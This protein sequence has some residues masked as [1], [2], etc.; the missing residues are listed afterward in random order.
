[1]IEIKPVTNLDAS[2]DIPASKSYANRALIVSSLA[3]GRTVLKN[4]I[5]CDDTS[6]MIDG[7]RCLGVNISQ[8]SDRL[9]V[10]GT[11]GNFKVK[12]Q[13]LFLGNAGTAVRFLTSFAVLSGDRV[14]I[15]GDDRMNQRPLQ[16]LLDGLNQLGGI[17]YSI[18]NNGCTPIIIEKGS[19]EGGTVS[20]N[21]SKSSQYLSSILM[22]GP[23]AKKDVCIKVKGNPV[24][25]PYIDVTIKV[26]N[27]FGVCVDN[28]DYKDFFIRSG[29]KYSGR[30]YT[31]E[32]DAS[33]AS[34]FFA[35]AAVT[36][37]RIRVSNIDYNTLQGDIH[38]LDLLEKM[39]C[40]IRVEKGYIE[41][42]G[43]RLHGIDVDMSNM[44]DVVQTLSIVS[45][46]AEGETKITN[47]HNLRIKETDRLSALSAELK[48]VGA[49][50]VEFKDGLI[51]SADRLRP[52]E[53]D[54]YNDHRMAMSFSILG[55]RLKG[56]KIK[57]PEC[58]AK[59]FPEFFNKLNHLTN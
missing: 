30:D 15:K 6:Y 54:T 46:F 25:M 52:A 12:Q 39:G 34:Y 23:Y 33:S 22:C 59:S 19:L 53:I 42:I 55:L 8:D 17:I 18:N 40:N 43:G 7:L 45:L 49:K 48:K 51:I 2:V 44:P 57:G 24:S 5:L 56:I 14:V 11:G 27:D 37:G 4:I 36:G 13:E 38:F 21:C 32:G 1:M 3:H 26:M 10:K 29:Q 31:V 9:M 50:A 58:V 41:V 35:A 28:R 20:L 47:V 16:D